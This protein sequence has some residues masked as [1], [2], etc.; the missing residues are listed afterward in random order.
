MEAGRN[1]LMQKPN[2][3]V[4][5]SERRAL[6][7]ARSSKFAVIRQLVLGPWARCCVILIYV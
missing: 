2:V 1:I 7:S 5:Q 4:S 6:G 3:K